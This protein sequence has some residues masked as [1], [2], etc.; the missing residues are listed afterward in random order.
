MKRSILSEALSRA[1]L[2]NLPEIAVL[3]A[4]PWAYRNRIR[5]LVQRQPDFALCYRR[6][7]SH[8][9]VAV[10][11]CPIAAP[12]LQRAIEVITANGSGLGLADLCE[13]IELFT[14]STSDK[15]LMSAHSLNSP[16]NGAALLEKSCTGLAESIPELFGATLFAHGD[17]ENHGQVLARWGEPSFTYHS[18]G[19]D[20]QVSLGSFFQ[21]NRFL[22]D[23]L[24]DLVTKGRR[25][26]LAWDLY[27][28]V[29]LFALRLAAVSRK[30]S[31]WKL[32]LLRGRPGFQSPRYIPQNGP[33]AHA[34]FSSAAVPRKNS[35]A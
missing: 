29:G 19:C 28:G 16:R 27:A 9:T 35:P 31:R 12:L 22:V 8:A 34:G 32:L 26:K 21:V 24:A 3:A 23:P 18:A 10:A 15:L 20:Y 33:H 1:K 14:N 25:G 17:D 2:K 6:G 11:Q 7:G 30:F 5:L 4:E 13:E